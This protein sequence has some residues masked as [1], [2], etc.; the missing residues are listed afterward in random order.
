MHILRCVGWKFRVKFQR[1]T[2]KFHTK[3]WTHTPQNVH[4]TVVI[5]SVWVTISL[6]CDIIRLSETDP[7]WP[8]GTSIF[9]APCGKLLPSTLKLENYGHILNNKVAEELWINILLY[10]LFYSNSISGSYVIHIVNSKFGYLTQFLYPRP[11]HAARCVQDQDNA[12]RPASENPECWWRWYRRGPLTWRI[13]LAIVWVVT[14]YLRL[15]K[16]NIL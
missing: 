8:M 6:N 16:Y 1:A 4:F 2:L 13:H 11:T 5:F 7:G 12:R 14:Y 9:E 3:F 10:T 15:N